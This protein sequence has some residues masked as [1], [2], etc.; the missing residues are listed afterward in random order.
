M[1]PLAR[2]G[3]LASVIAEEALVVERFAGDESTPDAEAAIRDRTG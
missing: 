2:P 1:V 3:G